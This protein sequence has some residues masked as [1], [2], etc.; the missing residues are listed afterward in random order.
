MNIYNDGKEMKTGK[1]KEKVWV[2]I[3]E[4]IVLGD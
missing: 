2:V 1:W 3:K 4:K